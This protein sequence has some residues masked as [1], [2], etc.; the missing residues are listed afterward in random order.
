MLNFLYNLILVVNCSSHFLDYQTTAHWEK[1][2]L[3]RMYY[4]KIPRIH[5]PSYKL[6]EIL[7]IQTS[8]CQNVLICQGSSQYLYQIEKENS[9][10]SEEQFKHG[11]LHHLSVSC[12]VLVCWCFGYWEDF[13]EDGV[14]WGLLWSLMDCNSENIVVDSFLWI[15][16]PGNFWTR[17]FT[18]FF[19][20]G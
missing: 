13:A 1:P 18:A 14:L 9:P 7:N 15:M 20:L 11:R 12:E 6:H 8:K 19:F 2:I 3:Q 5:Q 16:N 4:D 17:P 10:D